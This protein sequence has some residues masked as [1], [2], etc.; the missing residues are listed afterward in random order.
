MG[1]GAGAESRRGASAC[2]VWAGA[3]VGRRWSEP[4]KPQVGQLK[5]CDLGGGLAR[6]R[7]G[8]GDER[9]GEALAFGGWGVEGAYG[10]L[11]L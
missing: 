4:E 3:G 6:E 5:V 2:S 10:A 1:G 9:F 11:W 7:E 8:E